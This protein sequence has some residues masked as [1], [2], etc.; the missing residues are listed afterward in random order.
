MTSE[1]GICVSPVR[2][3]ASTS[4]PT[5]SPDSSAYGLVGQL[6]LV[7][8]DRDEKLGG[9]PGCIC[10]HCS[11]GVVHPNALAEPR[12]V[13]HRGVCRAEQLGRGLAV[14]PVDRRT[15]ADADEPRDSVD[16]DRSHQR[17]AKPVCDRRHIVGVA[18]MPQD[19]GELVPAQPRCRVVVERVG[20]QASPDLLEHEVALVMPRGCR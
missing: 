4:T 6:D 19:D 3:L 16:V 14:L 15:D 2:H 7:V 9:A 20:V 11:P 13:V 12:D 1:G 8:L 5:I 10:T 18:Q 17:L